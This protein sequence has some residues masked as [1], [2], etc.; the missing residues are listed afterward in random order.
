MHVWPCRHSARADRG[1]PLSADHTLA[2]LDVRPREVV[3]AYLEA[4]VQEHADR[5]P[6]GT[7]PTDFGD[8]AGVARNNGRSVR[9]G[10]VHTGVYLR[11]E[12]RHDALGRPPNARREHA[13]RVAHDKTE[14]RVT[15]FG[16]RDKQDPADRHIGRI[17]GD[18]VDSP[19]PDRTSA[20][21]G[22]NT[23]EC[24]AVA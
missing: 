4:P 2:E 24:L 23:R 13:W 5:Q 7:A 6:A 11:E 19:H 20:G 14:A 17:K 3:V 15:A 12:L 8:G 1:E 22:G 18:A 10:D 16:H 9:R 21:A